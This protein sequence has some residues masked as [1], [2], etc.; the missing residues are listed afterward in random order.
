[1]SG[2]IDLSSLLPGMA[3]DSPRLGVLA[4]LT[5]GVVESLAGGA[6]GSDDATRRFFN[7]RNFAFV[8]KQLREKLADEIMS[9][10]VQLQDLFEAL[11]ERQAQQE[12]QR[13]LASIRALC[14]QLLERHQLAA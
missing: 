12:F 13:E 1:M 6:L 3:D 7:A 11:P 14:L 10:G 9:R 4:L 2:I 5:L 8:R